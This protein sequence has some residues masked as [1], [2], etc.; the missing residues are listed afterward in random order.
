ME[1]QLSLMEEMDKKYKTG[2]EITAEIS[3][4]GK[5]GVILSL[6]G[7]KVDGII[8][9]KELALEKNLENYLSTIKV[10]DKVT[11]KVIKLKDEYGNV[12]LSRVEYEKKESIKEIENL[13]NN[14]ETFKVLIKQATEKGL[15]G[16]YK[17]VR[18]FI[19]GSH[20]DL[21][22]AKDRSNLIGTELEVKLIDYSIENPS[23]I[24]ASRKVILEEEQKIKEE[25]A[26]SKIKVGDSVKVEVKRFAKFG[27]FV[28]VYGIDGLIHLSQM[29]WSH[30]KSADSILKIGD[31]I[32][33]KIME[34]DREK[35]RLSLSI[36]NLTE[37]PWKNVEDKYP[38]GSVVLAKVVRIREF[39]AFV[40]LEAGVDGLVHISKITHDKIENP[41]EVLSIGDEVKAL[42][43]SVDVEN[44]KIALSIKDTE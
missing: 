17:G 42:I 4:I 28:D 20:V 29:S 24:I 44:K 40:E 21:R 5:E 23:K 39:G 8:P 6:V 9:F 26:W 32:E 33:A 19:P 15:I 16:Y 36:K 13:F 12:V 41:S 30:I 22:F 14:N 43:L 34:A 2:D 1:D 3:S 18:V 35:N 25:A 31:V 27:A 10:G 38:E 11:A 37:E 7:Y